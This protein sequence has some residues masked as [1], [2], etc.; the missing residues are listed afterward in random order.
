MRT[1]CLPLFSAL[2]MLLTALARTF[3]CTIMVAWKDG[4]KSLTLIL[5]ENIY[6]YKF[7]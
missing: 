7:F 2:L 6:D 4:R 3:M 5:K 1:W